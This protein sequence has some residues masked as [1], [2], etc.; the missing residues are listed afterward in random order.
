VQ[1][2]LGSNNRLLR[3]ALRSGYRGLVRL[4]PALPPPRVFVNGMPKSGNHLVRGVLERLPDMRY[5][6]VHI[7]SDVFGYTDG[8]SWA[9]PAPGAWKEVRSALDRVPNGH[10]ATAHLGAM[11]PG[12]DVVTA[13]TFKRIL[14][15]RD[16]RDVLVSF[17]LWV[18][19]VPSH[20][21][22]RRFHR[23]LPSNESRISACLDGLA[24]DGDGPGIESYP[25]RLQAYAG[26]LDDPECLIVRFED[27]IGPMGG[28]TR[29]AQV[30]TI[31]MIA[32]HVGRPLDPDATQRLAT[33][34][35]SERSRTFRRGAVG[36]WRNHL[37][38]SHLARLEAGA[39][40]IISALGYG[41]DDRQD[42]ARGDERALN[43]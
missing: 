41:L 37:T 5:S 4:R 1:R 43:D 36:D 29:D 30:A 27:L 10:F 35:W 32:R 25:E 3:D 13:L 20:H 31:D 40:E 38:Q 11:A 24:S 21:L 33:N 7:Q 15:V 14:I 12:M 39:G 6:G 9:C 18:P 8:R 2:R 23:D 17:A 22:Y 42:D 19:L 34:V 16:P 26:W 28:A